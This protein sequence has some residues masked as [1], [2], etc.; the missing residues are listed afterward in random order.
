M[1]IVYH[2]VAPERPRRVVVDATRAVRHVAHDDAFGIR[3]PLDDVDD[4]A[5]VHGEALGHLQRDSLRAILL[6][7]RDRFREFEIVIVGQESTDR[8]LEE[9]VLCVSVG[10]PECRGRNDRVFG[11]GSRATDESFTR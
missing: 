11:R 10:V 3:E 2:H 8:S 5:A 9:G 4:R 6:D 7:L 1:S